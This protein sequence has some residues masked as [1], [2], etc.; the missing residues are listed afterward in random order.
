MKF[1]N[2]LIFR[3]SSLIFQI[4]PFRI[5]Y[6]LSDFVAFLFA[7]VVRY[8]Y[9]V[10]KENIDRVYPETLTADKEHLIRKI[11]RNLADITVEGL[12]GISMTKKQIM[13]R[14]RVTNPQIL[15]SCYERGK[16]VILVTGHY[17][18][19]EW[20]AFSANYF[21]KHDIIGLYKP[22]TNEHVNNYV[23]RKR[24]NG[25]T[26]LADINETKKYFEEYVDKKVVFLMAGD[27][28]PTKPELAIW[29]DFLGI[30]TP[31]LHGLEKYAQEY[32]LPI[33][34]C[35]VQRVKRGQYELELSWI[36]DLDSPVME[37]GEITK[38]YMKKLEGIIQR[39]PENWLW[40]HR[41]WKHSPK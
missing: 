11:Y 35:D 5:I 33:I 16:S 32:N 2:Y 22:L 3:L 30:N 21:L 17:N 1:I 38:K 9:T 23:L 20:G 19:W 41:R 39:K 8:R 26:I 4:L 15:D 36:K 24:S 18:N 7:R 29:T 40:S 28:S 14:H 27:Q 6:F 34:Y 10:I 13:F 25:G 31:C 37:Y 12:K